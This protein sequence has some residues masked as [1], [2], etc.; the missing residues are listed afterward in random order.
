MEQSDQVAHG[1][2]RKPAVT[3]M[4]QAANR[5]VTRGPEPPG[6]FLPGKPHRPVRCGRS[7]DDRV[8]IL[9]PSSRTAGSPARGR[10]GCPRSSGFPAVSSSCSLT[11]QASGKE[12]GQDTLGLGSGDGAALISENTAA[13]RPLV[14]GRPRRLRPHGPLSRGWT[15]AE[16]LGVRHVVRGSVHQ[17]SSEGVVGH[18][19]DRNRGDQL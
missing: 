9:V 16:V 12:I 15:G 17:R 13:S 4:V 14:W 7:H 8:P 18:G 3:S 6:R 19:C 11:L 1:E 2:M 5:F 10:P